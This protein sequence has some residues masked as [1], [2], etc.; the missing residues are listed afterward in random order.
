MHKISY[1]GIITRKKRVLNEL[2]YV[3]HGSALISETSLVQNSNC[4]CGLRV[5]VN[6]SKILQAE[7]NTE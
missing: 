4:G 2:Y 1:R 3:M 5:K 7:C 6:E